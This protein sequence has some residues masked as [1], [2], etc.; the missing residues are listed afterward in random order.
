M[1]TL[2]D[3]VIFLYFCF[4]DLSHYNVVVRSNVNNKPEI[5]DIFLYNGSIKF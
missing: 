2:F 1:F 5:I 4:D 3:L